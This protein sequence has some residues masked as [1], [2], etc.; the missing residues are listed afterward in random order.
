MMMALFALSW[1]TTM[2]KGVQTLGSSLLMLVIAHCHLSIP[3]VS[4]SPRGPDDTISG[5]IQC[6]IS[7]QHMA[8]FA[9]KNLTGVTQSIKGL[10]KRTIS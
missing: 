3:G 1:A 6:V 9:P 8:V 7:L 4:S 5:V 2:Y 10:W